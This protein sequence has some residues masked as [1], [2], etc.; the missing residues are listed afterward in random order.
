MICFTAGD[1]SGESDPSLNPIISAGDPSTNNRAF[2]L[3][4]IKLKLD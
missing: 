4:A 2:S 3:S 1:P